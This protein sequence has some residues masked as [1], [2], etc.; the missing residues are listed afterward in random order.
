MAEGQL[1]CVGSSLFLKSKYGV[2]Y[3]LTIIKN[4]NV[5]EEAVEKEE[6]PLTQ[7][8]K[9]MENECCVGRDLNGILEGIV[10]GAVPSASVLSNVGTD[11]KFQL[12]IGESYGASSSQEVL[13]ITA[14]EDYRKEPRLQIDF[15]QTGSVPWVLVW[16]EGVGR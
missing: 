16:D 11:I 12:S 7:E 3:Q 15:E 13:H 2:G 6:E 10:E 8:E 1:R 4:S 5:G 14:S 9:S